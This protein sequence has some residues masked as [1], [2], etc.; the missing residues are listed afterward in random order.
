VTATWSRRAH[1]LSRALGWIVGVALITLAVV[2]ALAQVLLPALA[3]HPQWVAAQLGARLHRPVSFESMQG[4]WTPAGP[5]FALRGV[6]LGGAAPGQAPLRIP[7]VDATLDFGGW[8]LPSR[9]MLNLHVR[10]VQLDVARSKDGHWSIRGIGT[11]GGSSE[12]PM[13][14]GRLSLDLWLDDVHIDVAD[15]RTGRHYAVLADQLRAWL[16][17]GE[18]RVGA[19]LRRAGADGVLTAAGQFRDDGSNGR[20]WLAGDNLDVKAMLGDASLAGYTAEQGHGHL[21]AWLD[22]RDGK[23][24]R[25]VLQTDLTGVSLGTPVGSRVDVAAIRG[26]MEIRQ[27]GDGYRLA[28]AGYD[29]SALVAVM[30]RPSAEAIRIGIAASSLQLAPLVPWLALKPDMSAGL[31]HWLGEGKPRGEITRADVQWQRGVGLIR[32]DAAFQGLGIDPVG[33][34][35]GIDRLSGTLRGDAEALSL[36]LPQ[37]ATVLRFPKAFRQPFELS[38]LA[39]T[40]AVWHDDDGVHL[41]ADPLAFTGIGYAGEAR[42]EVLLPA[43]GGQPFLDLYAHIDH[44]D[45]TAAKLFWPLTMPPKAMAWLDRGLVGGTIDGG[46]ALVRGSLA[47]WPFLHDEGRFEAQARM[48]D[49][50]LDYGEGWPRAEHVSAVANFIDNGMLVQ[51]SGGDAMGVKA[52]RAVA[53]IPDFGDAALDLNVS[54]SGSG[55]S[56][57]GFVSH[58]PIAAREADTLAK[59]KLGGRGDFDFHLLLPFKDGASPQLNGTAQLSNADLSAPDWNLKL[60]QLSGPMQFDATGLSAGPLQGTFRSQPST[61]QMRIAG[62]TGD[63]DAV[64]SASLDGRFTLAELLRDQPAMAWLGAASEGRSEFRIGLDIGRDA[65]NAPLHQRLTIDS[66]LQDV[67][68]KLPAPLDKPAGVMMPLHVVLGLPTDSADLQVS[69]D[70]VMRARFRLPGGYGQPLAGTIALGDRMP[71]VLPTQ[72]LRVQGH[73]GRVDVSGWIQQVVGGQGSGSAPTLEGID[74]SADHAMLFGNDFPGLHMQV[75]PKPD[76]LGIDA[77]GAMLSGHFDV[78]AADLDKRGI[79]ARLK[80]LYWPKAEPPKDA[81]GKA[82]P[83]TGPTPAQAARTGVNPASL[84]P[85]HLLVDDLRLGN[86]HLGQARLESWPTAKGM[87]LDQLRALSPSVQI[88][89]SGDWNGTPEDSQTHLAIDFSA[90]DIGKMLDALGFDGLF[91]GGKTR[92]HLDGTWPGSPSAITLA[93][94]E[95]RLQVHVTDGRIPEADSPGVGRLLGLVSLAELP[96]RLTL[97]FGDVFGKGLAFDSIDGSFVFADGNATTQNMKIKGPAAEI[98]VT[99]RTG[100]R[101]RDYDQQLLVVPHVGNSLPVV[102]AVVA[103][104]VG[105]AAGLAVQGLLGRGL[106]RAASAR[107]SITG[108]WDKPVITLIEKRVPKPLPLLPA[109]ASST[110]P[111]PPLLPAPAA[112]APAH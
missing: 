33:A 91:N 82:L 68:I 75:T 67:A 20:V 13:S 21:E 66:A 63:P 89:A 56:L 40:V 87:H 51:A 32:L 9:H 52:Q 34:L 102:G 103:G 112:T 92:A 105:A 99:G 27:T 80:R 37:Q 10:G 78:P 84:P 8:L 39:G 60:G 16:G 3:Q 46:D 90:E 36:E 4:R 110:A 83:D 50:T 74:I 57:L 14:P 71:D 97:D 98:T 107:Y 7:E 22:W 44:G 47:D 54:G 65:A 100:L 59:L 30:H 18:V 1:R 58:S 62:A 35:P 5:T 29:G 108:S 43:G 6:T 79:T 81:S 55:A 64:L 42:G 70:E 17:S 93:N 25:S 38:R 45:V 28:W 53:L 104:P 11:A 48:S 24:V 31:S 86:A 15:E 19:R 61:L 101:A 26:V 94:L 73:G 2:A 111:T 109:P 23:V 96:R 88:T 85:F 69:L 49:L 12:Q 77:D 95:G 76:G 72:G 106:N 41:G